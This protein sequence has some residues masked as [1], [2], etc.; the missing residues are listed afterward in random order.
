MLFNLAGEAR[1]YE[2]VPLDIFNRSEAKFVVRGQ[3]VKA[4]LDD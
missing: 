3:A 1:V 4:I 2:E